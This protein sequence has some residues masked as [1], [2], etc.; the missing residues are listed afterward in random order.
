M[1]YILPSGLVLKKY[2]GSAAS[3][4]FEISPAAYNVPYFRKSLYKDLKNLSLPKAAGSWPNEGIV[5]D[6]N[7]INML[8]KFFIRI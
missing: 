1:E 3:I 2:V 8:I 4:E 6:N 7:N 5:K